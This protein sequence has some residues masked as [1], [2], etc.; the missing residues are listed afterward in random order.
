[1]TKSK[2]ERVADQIRTLLAEGR[3][4]PGKRLP[5][6]HELAARLGNPTRVS[7][8]TVR[9]A[10]I[11]LAA[12]G[13]VTSVRRQGW[14]AQMDE[15]IEYPFLTVSDNRKTAKSDVWNTWTASAGMSGG[16]NLTVHRETPPAHIAERLQLKP[17]EQCMVRV[18]HHLANGE[19]WMISTGYWPC[20]ITDNDSKMS[21]EGGN[22]LD[23]QNPSALKWAA[24]KGYPEVDVVHEFD[25]RLPLDDEIAI[26][27]IGSNAPVLLTYTT[28]AAREGR[29]FRCSV[30]VYPRHRFRLMAKHRKEAD[31]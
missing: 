26:L 13:L 18:R 22:E 1:V 7:R 12:E 17:H 21:L 20:W 15:R 29:P 25:A 5:S 30:N 16:N 19:K 2:T 24:L 4:M 31:Q 28:S 23:M 3:W 11:R 8:L 10:L 6:E 27:G 9:A 14:Y